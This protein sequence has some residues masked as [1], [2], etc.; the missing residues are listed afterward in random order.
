MS[1]STIADIKEMF[2]NVD[3]LVIQDLFSELHSADQVID[4]LISGDFQ[5]FKSNKRPEPKTEVDTEPAE[6]PKENYPHPKFQNRTNNFYQKRGGRG[7]YRQ[8]GQRD[9]N[10]NGQRKGNYNY[11]NKKSYDNTNYNH[12]SS[13]SNPSSYTPESSKPYGYQHSVSSEGLNPQQAQ[14]NTFEPSFQPQPV[15]EQNQVSNQSAP[16]SQPAQQ[17]ISQQQQFS[18]Q[19]AAAPYND[20]QYQNE[21]INQQPG[22]TYTPQSFMPQPIID[23]Q[24]LQQQQHQQPIPSFIF[25]PQPIPQM[26][27][28]FQPQQQIPPP[29]PQMMQGP[30]LTMPPHIA[31]IN[32]NMQIFGTFMP[33][34]T[35]FQMP[36]GYP[37]YPQQHDMFSPPGF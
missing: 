27:P 4:R 31:Q 22:F 29:T 1:S 32:P 3:E 19:P 20:N 24:T 8:Y 16:S 35:F 30:K 10:Y 6:A 17:N 2:P 37:S 5:S 7:G 33:M 13:R 36:Q 9:D 14:Q 23:P 11:Y 18:S 34:Q 26:N 25:A 12:Y 15:Q 21:A 28:Q